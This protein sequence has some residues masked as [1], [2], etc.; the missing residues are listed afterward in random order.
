MAEKISPQ[1]LRHPVDLLALG[2]GSGLLPRAPGTAGTIA[3]I[4]LY[5]VMQSLT[6]PVYVPLVAVLFLLGIPICAHTAKRLGVHDHP[7][8]VWDEIVGYLVTMT[9]APT[10]WLW[11][12]A[13]FVLFRFFDVLK[14]WPIRWLDRRVGGGFGI[15]VDDLL[16]GIAAAGVL[17]LLV[18]FL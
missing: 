16:A 17:Q 3:A 15:M 14:P 18:I 6:L 10:G 4:P 5:L 2:F 12:L 11:V 1:L 8:I 13:G 9:F 7:G